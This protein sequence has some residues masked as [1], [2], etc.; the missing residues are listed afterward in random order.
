[1]RVS[2]LHAAPRLHHPRLPP[3]PHPLAA[4]YRVTLEAL[5]ERRNTIAAISATLGPQAAAVVVPSLSAWLEQT[6]RH[7]SRLGT[8]EVGAVGGCWG[9]EVGCW[10][11]PCGIRPCQGAGRWVLGWGWEV[12]GG[13][14]G[15]HSRK[16]SHACLSPPSSPSPAPSRTT[17]TPRCCMPPCT[18]LRSDLP[19]SPHLTPPPHPLAQDDAHLSLLYASLRILSTVRRRLGE[20]SVGVCLTPSALQLLDHLLTTCLGAYQ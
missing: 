7:L 3:P 5:V 4:A 19:P 17:P 14:W 16:L 20:V 13:G 11:R 10:S 2:C 6:V 12:G 8:W 9:W 1:M 15:G 18:D